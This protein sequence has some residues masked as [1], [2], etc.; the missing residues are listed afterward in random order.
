MS[1]DCCVAVSRGGMGVSAMWYFLIILTILYVLNSPSFIAAIG[2]LVY[3]HKHTEYKK[4]LIRQLFQE[5]PDLGLLCLK[6]M[7]KC[8]SYIMSSKGTHQ[9][10]NDE[11]AGDSHH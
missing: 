1:Y 4:I 8:I 11:V 10:P 2:V 9:A 5:L 6:N 3:F 7:L